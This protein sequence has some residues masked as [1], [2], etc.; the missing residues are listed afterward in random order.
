MRALGERV[1]SFTPKQRKL[2]L[3]DSCKELNRFHFS[4]LTCSFA[5][6]CARSSA[7]RAVLSTVGQLRYNGISMRKKSIFPLAASVLLIFLF[8]Y[9]WNGHSAG[10]LC[11][12]TAPSTA[13]V[14]TVLVELFTSEGCS[15]CPPADRLLAKLDETQPI[16][17]VQ[18]VALSEHVDYWDR[19][20]WK[21]PFSSAQFTQRQTE[22]AKALHIEDIYTPQMVVDGRTEF[23]GNSADAARAAIAKAASTPKAEMNLTITASNPKSVTLAA[24]IENLAAEANGDTADVMLAIT[25]S[26]L[27]SKVLRG[28]NSGKELAHSVV[29]RKLVKIGSVTAKTFSAE[30]AVELNSAWKRQNLKA[31]VFVQERRGRRILGVAAIK[32]ANQG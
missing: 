5:S 24:H 31:V 11:R 6:E 8:A 12:P 10:T 28:E 4:N 20:G 26:G 23:I 21:D 32:L 25:E 30:R 3:R 7:G 14:S 22:Y 16:D 1:G 2:P 9:P 17:G 29:T 18:I 15:S 13:T 19:F 27:S